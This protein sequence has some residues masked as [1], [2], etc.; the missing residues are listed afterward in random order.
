ME[1]NR[2]SK[3][4]LLNPDTFSI[5]DGDH[6]GERISLVKPISAIQLIPKEDGKGARLGLI[7]QLGPGITIEI[8]G[9]G[10]NERMLKVRA[11]ELYFFVFAQDL[12]LS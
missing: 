3:N 6:G 7:S 2:S 9:D 8:C 1:Y 12:D 10:F 5:P 4:P 11:N